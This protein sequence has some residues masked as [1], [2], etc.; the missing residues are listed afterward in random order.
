MSSL[1]ASAGPL[2]LETGASTNITSGRSRPRRTPISIVAVTP[3][4][5]ICART[6]PA[7][8]AST[9]LPPNSTESTTSAVGSIV[10][11]TLASRTA[12]RRMAESFR[13]M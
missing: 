5:P 9:T 6:A 2:L 11:A 10:I 3:I 1:P 7:A 4:E 8:N 12:S 13:Q